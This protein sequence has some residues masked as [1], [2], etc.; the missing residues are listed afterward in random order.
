MGCITKTGLLIL[1][2]AIFAAGVA[3]VALASMI[4]HKDSS[5]GD[6]L[7]DGVFTLPI[8]ILIAGLIIVVIGFLG[9]CGA[10]QENSCMLRTYGLIVAVLLI[11]EVTLGILLLVYPGKAE[12]YIKD[13]M[14]KAF[15]KYGGEDEALNESIDQFQHDLECCGVSNYTDWNSYDYGTPTGNVA[16]SCCREVTEKCGTGQALLPAA[17][18]GNTIYTKGCFDAVKEDLQGETIG[19]CVVLFIMAIVQVMAVTCACG[20]AS[21]SGSS[22]YA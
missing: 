20:L 15:V 2:F 7:S 21:K 5:Y 6:M 8:I 12:E 3:V 11:A 14:T 1:N 16:D 22:H 13:G 18:A 10:A 19:L 4:I 9:C 17:V